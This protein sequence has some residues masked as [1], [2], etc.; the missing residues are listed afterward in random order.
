[1]S[2]RF[3]FLLNALKNEINL[4]VFLINDAIQPPIKLD[5]GCSIYILY[6]VEKRVREYGS[7]LRLLLLL[8]FLPRPSIE[9]N[10][11]KKTREQQKKSGWLNFFLNNWV[12][13]WIKMVQVVQSIFSLHIFFYV[14]FF[15]VASLAWYLCC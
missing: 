4:F 3:F 9:K 5:K 10:K 7:A 6:F 13:Y 1:M 12:T 2:K 14:L 15:I 11:K 8:L